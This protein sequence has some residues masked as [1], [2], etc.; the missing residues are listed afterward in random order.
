MRRG[1]VG[2]KYIL[3]AKE[4]VGERDEP[5]T[6]RG[7]VEGEG[8]GAGGGIGEWGGME[9]AHVRRESGAEGDKSKRGSKTEEET[10]AGK[11]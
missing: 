6:G 1:R 9:D 5:T 2:G 11:G 3:G 4:G 8:E 10:E 7:Q